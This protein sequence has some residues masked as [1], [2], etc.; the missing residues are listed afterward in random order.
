VARKAKEAEELREQEGMTQAAAVHPPTEIHS[1][2]LA[3]L[4]QVTVEETQANR[5][6]VAVK[7]ETT[8]TKSGMGEAEEVL[9]RTTP[10]GV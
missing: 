5:N 4:V 2:V 8:V 3:L 7:M 6:Q 10:A 1:L 9:P